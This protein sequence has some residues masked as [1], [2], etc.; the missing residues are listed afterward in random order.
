MKFFA[1]AFSIL[2]V[3]GCATIGREITDDQLAT[4]KKGETTAAQTVTT[5]GQPTSVTRTSDGRQILSYVFAH[6]QARPASF[7]PI[8]GIFAGGSD[9]R[10]SM[11]MLTFDKDG[12]FR[13][14]TSSQSVT[15]MGTGFA[16]GTY[17]QPDMTLPQE[18][19][20]P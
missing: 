10:S 17:T 3:V 11:V 7:I 1:F 6:A 2:L 5:L 19:K 8:V 20:K 14:Y 16:A 4:L 12:I 15:G 9:V 13:D 18:A